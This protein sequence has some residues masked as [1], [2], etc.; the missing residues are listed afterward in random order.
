MHKQIPSNPRQN[1]MPA[2]RTSNQ[3]DI[4]LVQNEQQQRSHDQ[5]ILNERKHELPALPRV[6]PN[7]AAE[8][9]LG[10]QRQNGHAGDRKRVQFVFGRDVVHAQIRRQDGL[11]QKPGP[12]QPQL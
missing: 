12:P 6:R 5:H 3:L 11:H 8:G 7:L 9:E 2:I 4:G 10:R 1:H